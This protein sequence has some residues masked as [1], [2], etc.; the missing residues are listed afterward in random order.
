[1]GF[2][3]SGPCCCCNIFDD[4]FDRSNT[5]DL[6]PDWDEVAGGWSI[7]SNVLYA[8]ATGSGNKL[9]ICEHDHPD[10]TCSAYVTVK[11]TGGG[12]LSKS[13]IV[14]NYDD[15][16]NYTYV[17]VQ[18]TTGPADDVLEIH[19]VTTGGG[20][21]TVDSV[22]FTHA[23]THELTVCHADDIIVARV[24]FGG[25]TRAV[26]AVA[27]TGTEPTV[28]LIAITAGA[29]N[30]GLNDFDFKRHKTDDLLQCPNCDGGACEAC[31]NSIKPASMK[32]VLGGSISTVL[33]AGGTCN[34]YLGT[35]LTPQMDE[36]ILPCD[37]IYAE[38]SPCTG[39][40]DAFSIRVDIG[41]L[42]V[43]VTV[44]SGGGD[45]VSWVQDYS[46]AP[47]CDNFDGE[48]LPYN[49]GGG[50]VCTWTSVTCELTAV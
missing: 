25:A 6:T 4:D 36:S 31:K 43:A 5:S 11:L 26:L 2:A 17:V 8:S 47:D 33:C 48:N 18:R 22:A 38:D 32:V 42:R 24:S 46:T 19:N 37:Y 44:V 3:F 30:S 50:S 9:L 7:I 29:Q 12:A 15:S 1:M 16:S 49:A 35:F 14:T 41:E 10:G 13:G 40:I 20:D 34:E 39:G 23:A 45:T 28:G 21:V 27:V